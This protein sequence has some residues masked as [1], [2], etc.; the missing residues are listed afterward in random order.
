MI[1]GIHLGKRRALSAVISDQGPFNLTAGIGPLGTKSVRLEFG[2][3]VNPCGEDLVSA[4]VR[5]VSHCGVV[6]SCLATRRTKRPSG[7]K[8]CHVLSAA[9]G[10][11]PGM[12]YSR[13]CLITKTFSART[14]TSGCVECLGAQ[15]IHFLV[16][17]L[18]VARRVDG[19]VF[20]FI[21]I[22]SFSET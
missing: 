8:R 20:N 6:V 1:G 16:S 18:T 2:N 9:R 21:P 13:A 17:V 12:I 10:R 22:R 4:N 7:G 14:R 3:K 19:N 5:G 15:F 11:P